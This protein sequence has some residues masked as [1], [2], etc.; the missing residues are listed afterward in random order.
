MPTRINACRCLGTSPGAQD[1]AGDKMVAGLVEAYKQ[2]IG[3]ETYIAAINAGVTHRQVL[4]F[5]KNRNV[6]AMPKAFPPEYLEGRALGIKH[7]D[8]MQNRRTPSELRTRIDARKAK[9]NRAD[10]TYYKDVLN[11]C[12][13]QLREVV[14]ARAAGMPHQHI[15]D[16]FEAA[17][18]VS[19]L[20]YASTVGGRHTHEAIIAAI[21]DGCTT[22]CY[23]SVIPL[24]PERLILE[25]AVQTRMAER[26]YGRNHNK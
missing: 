18:N 20:Y 17:G 25:C 23:C 4:A 16:F 15:V 8:L 21:T 6:I 1:D 5:G 3:V 11:L 9:I 14:A 26:K 24:T 19:M 2:G 7:A 10:Y 13:Q 22:V 12:I